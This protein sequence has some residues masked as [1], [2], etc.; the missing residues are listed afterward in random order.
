MI[1]LETCKKCV[2]FRNIETL[3]GTEYVVCTSTENIQRYIRHYDA[4]TFQNIHGTE[5]INCVHYDIGQLDFVTCY[6]F[7]EDPIFKVPLEPKSNQGRE[8]CFKCGTKTK[9]VSTG[10]F[11]VYDICPNCKI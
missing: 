1:D 3:W 10:M 7:L 5:K 4:Q 11:S 2:Y 9:K 8:Y 6:S